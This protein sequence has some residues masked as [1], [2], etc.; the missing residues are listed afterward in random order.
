V[1]FTHEKLL[2]LLATIVLT[3]GIDFIKPNVLLG[4]I[5]QISFQINMVIFKYSLPNKNMQVIALT[6]AHP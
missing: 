6:L 2:P 3:K 4:F 5:I 1:K